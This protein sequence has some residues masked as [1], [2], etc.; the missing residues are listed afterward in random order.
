MIFVWFV[1]V[2]VGWNLQS[3]LDVSQVY[4]ESHGIIFS[5]SKTVCI[6]LKDKSA[7]ST[8]T[9]LLTVG[10]QN[11]QSVTTTNIWGLY[12]IL[13]SQ[14]TKTFRENF[15]INI[16][17]QT[18]WELL[19][20]DVQM[21]LKMYFFVTSVRPCMHHKHGVISGSYACRDCV[22]P[23]IL[24]A[25]LY[26]TCC[27]ERVLVVITCNATFLPLRPWKCVP[28]GAGGRVQAHLQNFWFVENLGKNLWKSGQTSWKYGM[29]WR[30]TLQNHMK[31]FFGGHPK[32]CL[33]DLCGWKY[34][35]ENAL[36]KFGE[37]RPKI[38]RTPK[39]LPAATPMCVPVSWK[40][41]KV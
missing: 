5:C 15:D 19:V 10:G 4:A 17:Q 7:K 8:V 1:Q 24:G 37:I 22:R 35:R 38:L 23:I 33:H 32:K 28:G 41:Q 20:P 12:W 9:P 2:N 39:Y 11:V 29:S 30:P 16:V 3:M 40:M 14:M 34:S 6:T 31:T 36:G 27:G 25:G 26:T 13:S 21:Q 18:S